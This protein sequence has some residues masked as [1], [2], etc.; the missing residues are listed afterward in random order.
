MAHLENQ[1]FDWKLLNREEVPCPLCES[2]DRELYEKYGDEHQYSYMRC[3]HCEF[4]YQSPRFKYDELFLKWAYGA[5]GEAFERDAAAG[6][7]SQ[8][9]NAYFAFKKRILDRL[10]PT[11]PYRLLD[12]GAACGQ[13]LSFC[14]G[15]GCEATGLETSAQ[16]V[17]IARRH[18][19]F[20]MIEGTT[21]DIQDRKGYFDIVHIAH[22]LEHVPDPRQVLREIETITKPGGL[23]FVEVPNVRGLTNYRNHF[24][25]TRGWKKNTWKKGD[26]PEHLVEFTP[27]TLKQTIELMGWES[28]Y[29]QVHSK[30]AVEKRP[31]IAPFDL[32]FNKLVPYSDNMICVGRVPKARQ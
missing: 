2:S 6:Y 27:A 14:H 25:A 16:Q 19:P 4:I 3:T 23:V 29:F 7:P 5:Y 32:L 10:C 9:E 30:K 26:F 11:R 24:L 8:E 21:A 15:K 1:I 22:T 13:F 18:L 28:V 17:A 12:V 31:L 20:E